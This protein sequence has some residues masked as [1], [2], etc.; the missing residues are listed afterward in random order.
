[1]KLSET[2]ACLVGTPFVAH[3]TA[4]QFDLLSIEVPNPY[5]YSRVTPGMKFAGVELALK[6]SLPLADE[7]IERALEPLREK[8]AAPAARPPPAKSKGRG[9]LTWFGVFA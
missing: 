9:L 3:L 1:M 8:V 5:N 4:D 7:E 6:P 2:L